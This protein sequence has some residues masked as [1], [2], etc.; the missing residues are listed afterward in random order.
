MIIS[1][2]TSPLLVAKHPLAHKCLPQNWRRRCANSISSLWL[3]FTLNTASICLPTNRAAPTQTRAQGLSQHAPL[4]SLHPGP[5]RSLAPVRAPTT[6]LNSARRYLISYFVWLV[7]RYLCTWMFYLK[8]PPKG[9][10]LPYP[11][12]GE[13]NRSFAFTST[14]LIYSDE[15]CLK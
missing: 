13:T 2:V 9:E 6:S 3:V 14:Q 1:S 11:P 8:A 12:R 7:V 15:F 4:Q 5:C 10:G